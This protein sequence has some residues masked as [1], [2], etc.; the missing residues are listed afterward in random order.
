MARK[1]V[2]RTVAIATLISA[3]AAALLAVAVPELWHV[4]GDL[5]PVLLVDRWSVSESLHAPNMPEVSRLFSGEEDPETGARLSLM[6]RGSDAYKG[7]MLPNVRFVDNDDRSTEDIV[8]KPDG[9][10]FAFR[11]TYFKVQPGEIGRRPHIIQIYAP[12]KD[13]VVDE[14]ILRL[15]STNEEHTVNSEDG[16]KSVT[17]FGKDGQRIIHKLVIAARERTYLDPILQSDQRWSDD[18]AHQLTYSN[19][20]DPKDLTHTIREWDDQHD[21]IKVTHI[22]RYD[23]IVGTTILAYYP[24]GPALSGSALASTPHIRLD[25]E[26]NGSENVAKYFRKDDTLDHVLKLS[27]GYLVVQYF[28]PSGTKMLLEQ[29]WYVRDK[30]EQGKTT[31]IYSISTIKEMDAAGNPLRNYNYWDGALGSIDAYNVT[32][33]GVE[34]GEVDSVYDKDTHKLSRLMYWLGKADHKF[35]KDEYHKPEENIGLPD[36]PADLL[37]MRVDPEAD[38]LLIPPPMSPYGH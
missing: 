14:W 13:L 17:G 4:G 24:R 25:S 35:D 29:S 28:D 8:L 20:L 12:D 23:S 22:P 3:L 33:N 16:A 36:V 18:A 31:H 5:G 9:E 15:A 38:R 21:L 7:T 32:I 27:R 1:Q 11:Q 26:V 6:D 34:Y 10:H 37:K 19:I 30:V 2:I